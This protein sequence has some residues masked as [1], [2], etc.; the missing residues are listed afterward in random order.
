MVLT[1]SRVPSTIS[2]TNEDHQYWYGYRSE[3][4]Y[5]TSLDECVKKTTT[6][7]IRYSDL[8]HKQNQ[9][10]EQDKEKD[11]V[12]DKEKD[13]EQ[14]K[15]QKLELQNYQDQNLRQ[16]R[17]VQATNKPFLLHFSTIS[18]EIDDDIS[19]DSFVFIDG[20]NIPT[21]DYYPSYSD[22]ITYENWIL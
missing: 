5:N 15:E 7:I 12:K 18:K 10:K 4:T 14:E 6:A 3:Q 8:K 16:D 21:G 17:E 9:D 19:L 22:N 2:I 11:K 13:E 1:I 20:D